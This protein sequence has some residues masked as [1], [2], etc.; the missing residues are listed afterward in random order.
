MLADIRAAS[1]RRYAE[2]SLAYTFSHASETAR[3]DHEV[4]YVQRNLRKH[5]T[6]EFRDDSFLVSPQSRP[7]CVVLGN[8]GVGKSTMTQNL[9]H[10]L[11]RSGSPIAY[12]PLV[13]SCKDV[14][15]TDGAAYILSAIT[16]SLRENLQLEVPE[17]AVGDLATLG[18]SFVIFDGIDEIIDVGRRMTFVRTI[19]AFANRFP[20]IPIL[21]T[22]RRVGYSKAPFDTRHFDIYELDD[23]SLDQV[24]QY[25]EK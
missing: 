9:V 21:I 3:F 19:E 2:L 6:D 25:T 15:G 4:L 16:R 14:P 17:E 8:P 12:A 18:R 22:A 5:G 11:S 24:G 10:Q 20:L 13:V 23:F 7:R 1:E